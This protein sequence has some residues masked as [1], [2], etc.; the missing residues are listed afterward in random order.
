MSTCK[1]CQHW[2]RNTDSWDAP[3]AGS[4][5]SPKFEYA[6]G[7]DVPKDGLAYSDYEGYWASFET[8]EDFGCIHWKEPQ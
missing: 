2:K 6:D 4:C 7:N 8:G 1:T 3:H 5:S